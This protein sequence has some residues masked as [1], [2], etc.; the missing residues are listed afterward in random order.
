MNPLITRLGWLRRKL[1]L[2]LG[3]RGIFAVLG[4]LLGAGI[5]AGLLDWWLI[6]PSMVR[7]FLLAAILT[8][9]GLLAFTLLLQ[10]LMAPKDDLTLALRV[11]EEFPELNDAL[12]STV[13]FLKQPDNSELAG[14]MAM[15]SR[16]VQQALSRSDKCDFG[17]ILDRTGAMAAIGIFVVVAGL[18]GYFLFRFPDYSVTAAQ[19]LAD[20]FGNHTWTRIDMKAPERVAVEKPY[21]HKARL[22][23]VIPKTAK[24]EIEGAKKAEEV[25]V[26]EDRD[27][28]FVHVRLPLTKEPGTFRFRVLAGDGAFPPTPGSW[29]TVSVLDP[30]TLTKLDTTLEFPAYTEAPPH[31]V[32]TV[33]ELAHLSH[34]HF[35]PGSVVRLEGTA[36]RP[37]GKA[38]VEYRFSFDHAKPDENIRAAAVAGIFGAPLGAE[39]LPLA[40][41]SYAV[42]GRFPARFTD[43]TKKSFAIDFQP[44]LPGK[45][46]LHIEDEEEIDRELVGD[47]GLGFDAPPIVRLRLDHEDV[48]PE[49]FLHKFK[50]ERKEPLGRHD[51]YLELVPDAEL[52]LLVTAIEEK[53]LLRSM[54]LEM[55]PIHDDGTRRGLP[56]HVMIFERSEMGHMLP[57]LMG[58][59]AVFP[60]AGDIDIRWQRLEKVPAH[61]ALAKRF[62][63]GELISLKAAAFDNCDVFFDREPGRSDEIR[64]RI[65][66]KADL[67]KAEEDGLPDGQQDLEKAR[68]LLEDAMALIKEVRSKEELDR[69]KLLD[70][71]AKHKEVKEILKDRLKELEKRAATRKINKLP[72][73]EAGDLTKKMKNKLEGLLENE[74]NEISKQ[75]EDAEKSRDPLEQVE[76]LQKKTDAALADLSRMLDPY[77]SL[78]TIK[79]KAKELLTKQENIRNKTDELQTREDKIKEMPERDKRRAEKDFKD[80]LAAAADAQTDLA[81]KTNE[82][83]KM[84]AD[85]GK[86]RSAEGDMETS[87]K[88]KKAHDLGTNE[89]ISDKMRETGGAMKKEKPHLHKA[90]QQQDNIKADLTKLNDILNDKKPTKEMDLLAKKR[91]D[92]KEN[93]ERL[94]KAAK[95]LEN[96]K[97][98]AAK[99]GAIEDPK[100]RDEELG[101]IAKEEAKL[102]AELEEAA[103]ALAKLNEPEAAKALA[104]AAAELK[105][106]GKGGDTE[107]NAEAAM[108]KLKDLEDELK[109]VQNELDREQLAQIADQIKGLKERQDEAIVRNDELHKKLM[110]RKLWTDGL[111]DTLDGSILAQ[112]GIAKEVRGLKEKLKDAIVFEHIM[113][114]AARS[115]ERAVEEMNKRK[116]EAKGRRVDTMVKEELADEDKRHAEIK[117]HQ[118]AGS[119]R[120]ER[121]LE[122]IKNELPPPVA[123]KD[124]KKDKKGEEPPKVDGGGGGGGPGDT[125]PPI[126]QLKALKAEQMDVR[127]RTKEF[128]ARHPD[129]MALEEA[130]RRE[131]QELQDDQLRIHQ[132][133]E[134]MTTPPD[135]KGG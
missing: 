43:D 77:A 47:I 14:S 80:D 11:E 102:K 55:T 13:Q 74:L 67:L 9:A 26:E 58:G 54:F 38:W 109:A 119:E 2:V 69:K 92:N 117:K 134:R 97:D 104:D 53:Y 121:M 108:E 94:A 66:P 64:I 32:T 133:F 62:K 105:G 127:E 96:L 70:A 83:L 63:L 10:P 81:N 28:S 27:G 30:P 45:Y 33:G 7:A 16:A 39:G 57:S 6:L 68:A 72:F 41:G 131:L 106:D 48:D 84:I 126:A 18:V 19:R 107:K 76:D 99:A 50:D 20:P 42:H 61:L 75:L 25:N 51:V 114:K 78:Q 111:E 98:R 135:K 5:L 125:I 101:K 129:R 73:T 21:A 31:A 122:A 1:Y 3:A 17:R 100:K 120:L 12:G 60:P 37:L 123:K 112:E 79:A 59:L 130:A 88:L 87:S 22:G 118:V 23:G 65:V 91:K 71:A 128:D 15:R 4:L 90:M 29:H 93:I 124:E 132:L 110:D 89:K 113:D 8:G 103:R 86:K 115:M 40:V 82:L 49:L 36:D 116:E 95:D 46:L 52:D 44:W 24:I 35:V 34:A 56:H 85:A